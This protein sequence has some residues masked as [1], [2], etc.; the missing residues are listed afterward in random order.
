MRKEFV[1]CKLVSL[2]SCALFLCITTETWAFEQE[3][4]NTPDTLIQQVSPG[5]LKE[6]FTGISLG[7]G[8]K[9]YTTLTSRYR[10]RA[11]D[12]A[13][14]QDF[15]QYL[16][17]HTDQMKL[18]SG[19]VRLSAFGR[20]AKDLNDDNNKTVGNSYY[21]FQDALDTQLQHNNFAPRLYLGQATFDGVI[22][23][24]TLNLGRINLTHQNTFQID[25]GDAQ[26]KLSEAISLYAYGGKPVSYYYTSGSDNLFGGGLKLKAGDTTTLGAEYARLHIKASEN[27]YT[28][29]R[30]DQIIPHGSAALT[31]TLLDKSSAVNADV[32][33]EIPASKTLLTAKYEGLLSE[34]KKSVGYPTD[35]MTNVLGGQS[36]YNKYNI[37]VYQPFLKHF[38]VGVNYVQRMVSG[39]EDYNN[40]EYSNIKGK[41]DMY[42]LPIQ[43]SYIS[44]MMDYWDIKSTTMSKSNNNIQ[45]GV[46]LSQKI[47]KEIDLWGGTAYNRYDHDLNINLTQDKVKDWARSYYLGGQYQPTKQL[48]FMTDLSIERTNTYNDISSDLKTN[49]KAEIW[50]SFLF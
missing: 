6:S 32:N 37:G 35:P 2:L 5:Q 41:I 43:N 44:F 42:D 49:Y 40:R 24:T 39:T 10:L 34:L 8:T 7:G 19:T 50:A 22:K 13:N 18:G 28:K 48:S 33:Y 26:Y 38:A 1:G 11:N 29:L 3:G 9:I 12:Y 47:N 20:F 14:D 25:G 36:K 17:V 27:D 16:R 4:Y 46:Q 45:Y 15:Y 21:F 31:Y 23:N 30:I